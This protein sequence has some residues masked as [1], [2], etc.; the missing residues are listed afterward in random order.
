VRR[1]LSSEHAGPLA[2]IIDQA[3]PEQAA[4]P[5]RWQQDAI[6]PWRRVP[7]K[8]VCEVRVTNLDD[9]RW[10]RFP[11]AFLQWRFDRAPES[12]AIEQL[13]F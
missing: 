11:A 12:C 4:I 10:A 3:G 13:L 2:E 5:S 8:L 9:G 7:V 1:P 6:P